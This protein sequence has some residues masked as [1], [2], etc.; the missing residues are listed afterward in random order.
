MKRCLEG[1]GASSN[2]DDS[3]EDFTGEDADIDA[4]DELLDRFASVE[5]SVKELSGKVQSIYGLIDSAVKL[6]SMGQKS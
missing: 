1:E 6:S 5:L 4:L 3:D 2:A